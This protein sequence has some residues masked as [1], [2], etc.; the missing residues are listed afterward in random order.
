VKKNGGSLV[1]VTKN[2][3]DLVWDKDR[4]SRP[5]EKVKA[6]PE[7]FAGK[8][9]QEKIEELRKELQKKKRAG[10]V[11]CMYCTPIGFPEQT[12]LTSVPSHA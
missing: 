5:N 11:I 8:P 12:M 4:P 6:H 3:I 2:L 10:F 1:A 7:V 9:F